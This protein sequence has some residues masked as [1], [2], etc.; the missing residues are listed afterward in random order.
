A[1]GCGLCLFITGLVVMRRAGGA[2]PVKS[3]KPPGY[4]RDRVAVLLALVTVV[5]LGSAFF[6]ARDTRF[7]MPGPLSS[8]HGTVET[9]NACHTSSGSR[10]LGWMNALFA[11]D[12]LLDSRACL[13]CHKMPDTA[14]NAHSAS[15]E[16]LERST[17]RLKKIA[18]AT[19]VPQWARAQTAAFPTHDMVS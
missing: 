3:P 4:W 7:L 19:P 15:P 13:T 6:L 8:G 18:R 2:R 10:K 17:G 12:A 1:R 5:C 9:C 11:G 14:F 16:V